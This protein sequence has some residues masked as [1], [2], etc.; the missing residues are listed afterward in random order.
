M[1]NSYVITYCL[2]TV[3]LI[4]VSILSFKVKFKKKETKY[5]LLF[6]IIISALIAAFRPEESQDTNAYNI[7]YENSLYYLEN[8]SLTDF[9]SI[10]AK[11][12]NYIELPYIAI[13]ACFRA[14]I[15]T[16]MFFYFVQAIISNALMTQGLFLMCEYIYCLE[17]EQDRDK[18]FCN[19]IVLIFSMYQLFCG[20]LYTSSAIRA[21]L[22]LSFGIFS[23]AC[24]LTKKRRI[25]AV[26]L[27]LASVFI[28]TSSFVLILI[29]VLIKLC[30][31]RITR[32]TS[33]TLCAVIPV[34]YFSRVGAYFVKG[35]TYVLELIL[36]IFHVQAFQSYIKRLDFS[37]PLREGFIIIL[38]CFIIALCTKIKHIDVKVTKLLTI[39]F[40]GLFVFILAYPIH[41]LARLLYIF[42]L[43]LIPIAVDARKSSVLV[44]GMW[45]FYFVP[46]YVYVFWYV[47]NYLQEK[48]IH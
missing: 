18:F 35:F 40:I 36:Q 21:G 47:M 39:V 1:F 4:I 16:P 10:I 32:L 19:N 44:F 5:F 33:L 28:H 23:I 11:R 43:V 24:I 26:A 22:S 34:L 8:S 30:N 38:T 7:V 46:Q 29:L 3:L 13:M 20:V 41:A 45:V 48:G 6:L 14:I 37:L 42:I 2:Y 25:I 9:L 12:Y 15:P 27:L 31:K 17:N